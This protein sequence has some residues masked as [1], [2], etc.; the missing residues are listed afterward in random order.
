MGKVDF[1]HT[2]I[3][4][5]IKSLPCSGSSGSPQDWGLPCF[6]GGFSGPVKIRLTVRPKKSSNTGFFSAVTCPRC[7]PA[8]YSSTHWCIQPK[9]GTETHLW[10]RHAL[11][12]PLVNQWVE[13]HSENFLNRPAPTVVPCCCACLTGNLKLGRRYKCRHACIFFMWAKQLV[14]MTQSFGKKLLLRGLNV[15]FNEA[16]DELSN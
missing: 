10:K 7:H 8:C 11:L 12:C 13:H 2:C 6:P 15:L 3:D 9:S 1:I 16:H 14:A 5:N 4:H